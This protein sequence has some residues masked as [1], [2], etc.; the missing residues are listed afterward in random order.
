M[1]FSVFLAL[2]SILATSSAAPTPGN[3]VNPE[4]YDLTPLDTP[5]SVNNLPPP[6]EAPVAV[7]ADS[8]GTE[9]NNH[10]NA[11]THAAVG[12]CGH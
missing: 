11:D 9:A 4:G 10:A 7:A 6:G 2:A 12:P 5:G 3:T 1:K 8:A